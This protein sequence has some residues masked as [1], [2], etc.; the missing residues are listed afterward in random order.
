MIHDAS[1]STLLSRLAPLDFVQ[2]FSPTDLE[3]ARTYYRDGR[4][5]KLEIQKSGE[6]ISGIIV[7]SNDHVYRV[8]ITLKAQPG[9]KV[10]IEGECSCPVGF[11]CKH[12]AAVLFNAQAHASTSA[13]AHAVQPHTAPRPTEAALPYDI[14]L[15]LNAIELAARPEIG[16]DTL[17]DDTP[18]R[19]LYV[20]KPGNNR[21]PR[22]DVQFFTARL[23]KSGG[24]GKASLHGSVLNAQHNPSP[25]YFTGRDREIVAAMNMLRAAG[26][27]HQGLSDEQGV[28]LIT[29]MIATGRCFWEIPE[30]APLSLGE[31]RH[32]C[33]VWQM[34]EQGNQKLTF[35]LPQP[36]GAPP[37]TARVL[38]FSPPWYVDEDTRVCG[39]LDTGLPGKIAHALMAAPTIPPNLAARIGMQ[40][41]QKL[42]AQAAPLPR[43]LR[44]REVNDMQPIPCLRLLSVEKPAQPYPYYFRNIQTRPEILDLAQVEFDYNGARIGILSMDKVISRRAGDELLHIARNISAEQRHINIL[45]MTG[46][47][48]AQSTGYQITGKYQDAFFLEGEIKE[49]RD[50]WVEFCLF[51]LPKLKA[52]G[53]RVE[54][55]NTFRFKFAEV[56]D[57]TATVDEG[58]GND[59]FGLQLGIQVDGQAV[60]LLPVLLNL[61]RQF[62]EKLTAEAL[63]KM[64]DENGVLIG[65]L[66]DGRLLSL[67]ASRVRGILSVLV[68]LFDK[69]ANP[70]RLELSLVQAARLAELDDSVTGMRWM[71]GERLRELGTKLRNF[72]GIQPVAPPLGLQAELRGYQQ[73]G[74]NWLQ[75]LREYDL[76][77]ILADD[78]GL[79]KTVQALAHLLAEKESGRMDRPSLVVAP[80]SLMF[81]WRREA[82]RFAP[83]LRVLVLQGLGRKQHFESIGAY[84]LVL[85]TYPLL[86]R[87]KEVLVEQE[88]HYLILDEAHI[89][90]NPKSQATR[91]VHQI[92]ARHR[93]ALTGT[94]LENHLGEL[95]TLF[96]FLLPGLLG[97]DKQFRKLFRTPIEKQGDTGRRGGLARRI[98]PFLLRR[99]KAQVA[100]ELPPKTEIVRYCELGGAQRDLYEAVRVAMHEKVRMEIDRKGMNR[101][102][103]VILDALLKLRQACCDPRLL[104]LPAAQLVNQSAKLELLMSLLPEMLEAGRR[105]LLFSQFTSMLALIELELVKHGL[106]YV[107]L[108]GETLDRAT[109]VNRFQNG[110]APLFLISL[111]AGGVGLNLTAADTVIHYDPWWNP[112][113]ENQATDRAHRI[114]QENPVF[115]YKLIT[116]GTVEEKIVSLQGKKRDLAQGVLDGDGAAAAPLTAEDLTML[117]EPLVG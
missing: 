69:E 20:L 33:P 31:K 65:N 75:F 18:Q 44:E 34:D 9:G 83:G 85:T 7:G 37:L 54:I 53:W 79:G 116:E 103:I 82:E 72:Q 38:P 59:W 98:A 39:E 110:E 60:N 108:T 12:V 87:D 6:V 23:L 97:D 4:V 32:A 55:D 46:L 96:H 106:D 115:V 24:L 8:Y 26:S 21:P 28:R 70:E 27:S 64:A 117:F 16:K 91:I 58:G 107:K 49:D 47:L 50:G 22:L 71:G 94:P 95:W 74:L 52:A 14:T 100:G 102:Q 29:E 35:E 11:N 41:A 13:P 77:G 111:K 25:R 92:K 57:W 105:I 51:E 89:I 84:D 56:E 80:T 90:K 99:T 3:R 15:W 30:S 1:S 17:P 104:K 2:S 113:V 66:P 40:L 63:E 62:P 112:A 109:P 93:L 88:F 10:Q 68:E 36:D 76:A 5:T 114:G 78:M 73:E 67:P 42:P 81:N 61:I 86:P 48:P 101:S 45:T 43:K 19:L